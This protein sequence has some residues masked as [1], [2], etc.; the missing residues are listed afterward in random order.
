MQQ[1]VGVLYILTSKFPS[2]HLR[3]ASF[4]HLNLQNCSTIVV[5]C[6]FWLRNV[7]RAAGRAIFADQKWQNRSR[8]DVFCSF[9]LANVLRA[10]AACHLSSVCWTAT[11]APAA[12]ARLFFEHACVDLLS[13][14]FTCVLIF[15]CWLDICTLLFTPADLTSLLCFSTLHIVG[16]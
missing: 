11:S 15:F 4:G 8:T 6:A 16:N 2:R 14:N 5:F 7:L 9:W 13:S 1:K 10:T 12:L 3:R